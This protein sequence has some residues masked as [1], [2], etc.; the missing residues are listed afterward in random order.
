MSL[1]NIKAKFQ[2]QQGFTIVELLIVIVVIAILAAITIVSYNGITA[3]ANTSSAQSAASTVI[4]KAEAYNADAS[5]SGYPTTSAQL[6]NATA[7]HPYAVSGITFRTG[8]TQ[9]SSSSQPTAPSQVMLVTCGA[10][11][12]VKVGYYDYSTGAPVWLYTGSATSTNCT[13]TTGV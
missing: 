12:G 4:K 9:F 13:G 3:R 10:T 2:A 5:T 11:V 6:A 7:T 1:A 8:T